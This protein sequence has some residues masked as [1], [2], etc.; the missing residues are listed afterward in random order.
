MGKKI[1][2][3]AAAALA[4]APILI[5][6]LAGTASADVSV[7]QK[8]KASNYSCGANDRVTG[9]TVWYGPVPTKQR[10]MIFRNCSSKA[11][12]K[13][14]DVYLDTDGKCTSIPAKS[15]MVIHTVQALPSRKVYNGVKSC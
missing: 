6:S 13:K 2:V 4:T 15:A 3:R 11:V 1:L 9:D 8:V 14:A 12:K 10:A 7:G 5:A